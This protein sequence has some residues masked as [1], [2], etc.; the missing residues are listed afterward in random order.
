MSRN[1]SDRFCTTLQLVVLLA[2]ILVG[3]G[4]PHNKRYQIQDGGLLSGTPCPPPCYYGII[5]GSTTLSEAETMLRS[6]G[7]CSQ[8]LYVRSSSGEPDGIHCDN[9][10]Y[11]STDSKKV[12]TRLIAFDPPETLTVGMVV[13]RL[14]YP[15][16]VGVNAFLSG[17]E[18][19]SLMFLYYQNGL[20]R[21]I[22]PEQEGAKYRLDKDTRVFTIIYNE[23]GF[24]VEL[25][26][27]TVP[28]AGFGRYEDTY[29]DW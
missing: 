10:I 12:V 28:W 6:E 23:E 9:G 20:I 2:L 24:F 4:S 14:G 22:L 8:P 27:P 13:D 25:L 19:R 18:Q 26:G 15:D 7:L 1:M 3:C 21:L 17:D 5:P 11:V 16:A 29:E